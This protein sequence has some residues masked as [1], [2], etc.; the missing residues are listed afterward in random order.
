MRVRRKKF[1]EKHLERALHSELNRRNFERA[2]EKYSRLRG[3]SRDTLIRCSESPVREF[4]AFTN[5]RTL[6]YPV[7]D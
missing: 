6:S 5:A 4:V 7:D 3:E 1:G 2:A